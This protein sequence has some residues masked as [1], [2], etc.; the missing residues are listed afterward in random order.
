MNLP[1]SYIYNASAEIAAANDPLI[2]LFTVPSIY[3]ATP[4]TRFNIS[5]SPP[6]GALR[7]VNTTS[8][9][10]HSFSAVCYLTAR[11]IM[12]MQVRRHYHLGLIHAS[13]AGT[14]VQLWSPPAVFAH[15]DAAFPSY[16]AN[17]GQLFNGMIAPLVAYSLKAVLWC[18]WALNLPIAGLLSA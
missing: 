4:Q 13:V 12:R 9:T 10:V 1:M 7:W 3:S 16:D 2:R 14:G 6:A 17:K 8:D 5:G 11:D 15:C 18:V